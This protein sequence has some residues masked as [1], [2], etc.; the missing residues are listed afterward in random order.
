M[1]YSHWFCACAIVLAFWFAGCSKHVT[2]PD[3]RLVTGTVV[4]NGAPVEAAR[5]SFVPIDGNG[6]GASGFTNAHGVY[7]L[8]S[9]HLVHPGSGTRPGQYQV[10]IQK[11]ETVT[12]P[13]VQDEEDLKAGRITKEQFIKREIDRNYSDSNQ[14]REP[15]KSLVPLI[16]S[17][18]ATTPLK[19][20]VEDKP[21]NVIDLNL[22]GKIE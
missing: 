4:Y 18:P 15:S 17:K 9:S 3:V 11:T 1:K 16:Y 7:T 14:K 2:D 19:V 10:I 20:V 21:S 6:A 5:V 22:E 8:T 12:D 13:S